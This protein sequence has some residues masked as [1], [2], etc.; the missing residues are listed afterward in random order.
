[1]QPKTEMVP[2]GCGFNQSETFYRLCVTS[3]LVDK[4]NGELI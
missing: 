2:K 3:M 4:G 1:M